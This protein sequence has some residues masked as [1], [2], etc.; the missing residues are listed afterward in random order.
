MIGAYWIDERGQKGEPLLFQVAT[1]RDGKITDL[2]DYRRRE[3]ALSAAKKA[4]GRSG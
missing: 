2:R 3:E 4:A 1:M